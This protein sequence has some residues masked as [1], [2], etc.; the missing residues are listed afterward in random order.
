MN[1]ELAGLLED[2]ELDELQELL[3]ARDD[4]DGLLLDS[5]QGLIT[6]L[7]I[8]PVRVAP[9]EWMPYVIDADRVFESA[10]QAERMVK[11]LLRLH[12]SVVEDIETLMYE[13]ILGHEE[14]ESGEV[15]LSAHGWCEGF[16]LGVDL[17]N[18]LWETRM[19]DDPRLLEMLA[20]VVQLA[21]DEGVFEHDEGEEPAPLSEAEYEDALV[22]LPGAVLDTQQ[23]WRDHPPGSAIE[24]P[25]AGE[26][27]IVPRRRGGRSVH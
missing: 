15:A 11:L 17:R 22:R 16:S 7:A 14:T 20:P 2:N 27:R 9:E 19:R 21:A 23:Y 18:E 10:E 25:P 4:R 24:Q 12:A 1:E 26:Q 8:G 13:P 5:V 6:A 3:L